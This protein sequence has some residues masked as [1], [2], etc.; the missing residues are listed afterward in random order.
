M[1]P[2]TLAIL[3]FIGIVGIA[4]L[5]SLLGHLL[6]AAA[7]ILAIMNDLMD[8]GIVSVMP[9]LGWIADIAVFFILLLVYRNAGALISLLDLV[10]GYSFLPF[11]T[12]SLLVSWK[13]K[14]RREETV[15]VVKK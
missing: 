15:Y 7:I 1:D 14:Q 9:E 8:L 4:M 11:H 3:V 10:P 13:I 2:V 5:G 6:G 12:L